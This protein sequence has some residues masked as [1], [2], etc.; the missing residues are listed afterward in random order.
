MKSY[1]EHV[2][3]QE[4]F[5]IRKLSVG[6]VS[7]AI[8]GL[9]T[10]N[11]YGA[12]VKADEATVPATEATTTDTATSDAAVSTSSKLTS[13]TVTEGNKTVTT[14]YVESPELEKAK[15]D[16]ATEGVTVTEEAE[17]V[18]PSIAAAEADNKAQTAEIN[19]VV[20]N[21]KKAKAEYEAKS[22]EITLIEKRNADA[23]ADYQ[24]KTAKYN[25]EKAAYDKAL[26]EYNTKK[27]A[28][29]AKVAEKAA[30]D[31][32]NADAKAKYDAEMAVYN[33]AKAQYD[34]D[35]QEY[36]AKKAQYDKDKEAYSKLVA[37]KAEED[38]AKKKY[39]ADLNTYNVK[40]VQYEND[41]IAYQKKLAEY[42]I[43]KKQYTDAKQAYDK[44][45]TDNAYADLK[46]VST[47]QDLTFQ[48]EGGA[49]HTI[50]GISTY[51]TRDAQA[52]LNTSNVQQYDSNKLEASDIVATSPWA[53]NETE[54]IQVKEGDKFVVTYDN[55]N[56]SSMR[57]DTYMHPIKR[58]IYRYEILSLPSNDGKGI[59][60]V[61]ADPTITLTV[62]ASTDQDKPVKVAVDVEFYD[63]D[64]K[65]FD[66]TKRN[67]IVALNSLN[68]WTGAS[69]VDS[70]DKPRA[71][72]VEAKDK[73]GKTVRGTWDPY[74]DGSSMSIENN[75]V[76]VK[77]G[78]ANFG[79]ATVSISADNPLKIVKQTYGYV[80]VEAG[81]WAPGTTP[82]KEEVTDALTVNAS[83]S[84]SVHSIGTEEFTFEGKDDVL[85]SYKVDAT[86]GQITFT[87]KKK[88]ET[89]DHQESVNI[90]NNKFIPIPNSSVSYDAA[91]KEVTSFKDNQYIEHGSV[92]NGETSST[93]EGWDNPSSKYL[94]YGGAGLKMSDGHLVF[95]ANGAN[96]AGQPTVYWFAIN[97]NVGLPKEPGE[98]PKEPTKPTEPTAPTPPT[99]TVENLPAE[100]TKPE[101]PKSP[102][103]PTAPKYTVITVDVEEPTAPTPPTQPTPPTPEVVPNTKP[104]K[105]E[106]EV[107]WHKNKVV[108]ETDIPTPPTPVPPTPEVPTKPTPEVPEQ[109]VEPEQ[110]QT[111]ALP[112]TGTESS[113]AAVLA[114]AM[115][116]LLGLGL[117]RK[118]KED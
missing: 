92:F 77:T 54:Y 68:H 47:V 52:R 115:A 50:D 18:Q 7:L 53:N 13:T 31:K 110:R 79:D 103:P 32:A 118:K 102:T 30:A 112:N 45:M 98:E 43:A 34:K 90:G 10:V 67:A 88:F 14:T 57:E 37:K 70:G 8:A 87:P 95:T 94:Y 23:E 16:A 42:E 4:K 85:G 104:V 5:S 38:A 11:T 71:L 46:N 36:Q 59:A 93:L 105:P 69:Y 113:P 84:G 89:V 9:A 55:L 56:Q 66:L 44:Y 106:A 19:T 2:S 51:L 65:K 25:Q 75:E 91:T 117:A 76:K 83:G 20:E 17:K 26:E 33:T 29:D 100:P 63:G 58:V 62:G 111:P 109:P 97:S 82:E 48:R 81:K 80:E 86:T 12:E 116:G 41:Y 99:I 39:D 40:K 22:Q 15:A 27:A 61:S 28:Y 6:V 3:K 60:A 24:K 49:T 107:K 114:G 1:R 72:T 74:A 73:D 101:E 35:L 108:T 64:G 96:A 78:R 21:Y